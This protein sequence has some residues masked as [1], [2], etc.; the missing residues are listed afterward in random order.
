MRKAVE[1]YVVRDF[2]LKYHYKNFIKVNVFKQVEIVFNIQNSLKFENIFLLEKLIYFKE[3]IGQKFIVKIYKSKDY[4]SKSINIMLKV[5]FK[6]KKKYEFLS[7]LSIFI[8]I[9]YLKKYGYGFMADKN[10]NNNNKT[11]LLDLADKNIVY[12]LGK[13]IDSKDN[14]LFYLY[15][16]Y[17]KN[18]Y[19]NADRYVLESL[20]LLNNLRIKN[21]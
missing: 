4:N 19:R 13:S 10:K 9:G 21:E 14:I 7:Y 16:G 3:L 1:E 5:N 11:L 18:I 6:K 17:N 2:F 15:F 12:R 8:L 20:K